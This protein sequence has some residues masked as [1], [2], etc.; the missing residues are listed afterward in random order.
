MVKQITK[1]S[2]L[3][4]NELASIKKL[5]DLSSAQDKFKPK[6]YW[7]I[8]QDRQTQ[9]F[10]DFL[11]YIDGNLVGYLALFTFKPDEAELSAMVH[12]KYR[13]QQIFKNLL[14]EAALELNKRRIKSILVIS[15][16]HSSFADYLQQRGA[17]YC[18][19]HV[20]MTALNPPLEKT[21]PEVE[22][23]LTNNDDLMTLAKIGAACFNTPFLEVL[24]R[25]VENSRDRNRRAWLLILNNEFIGK[26]HVRFEDTKTAFIHDLCII[27]E[28]RGQNYAMAMILKTMNM[29]KSEGYKNFTLDVECHNEGALKLYEQC[30][31]VTTSSYDFWKLD[32]NHIK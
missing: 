10:N 8:L 1:S 29:L 19:S 2:R 16:P 27:P 30:G 4:K 17:T 20:E 23:K 24:Q 12:P 7:N 6:F 11:Y 25:F 5:H 18:Y 22:L 13:R 32:V 15:Q 3:Y 26:I 21:L 9:E 28:K 14:D 31:Y